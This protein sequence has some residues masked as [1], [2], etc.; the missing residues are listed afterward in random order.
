MKKLYFIGLCIIA[1]ASCSPTN[2]D[3]QNLGNLNQSAS[4]GFRGDDG[5][6]FGGGSKPFDEDDMPS[7]GI[8]VK[9]TEPPKPI[10]GFYSAALKRHAYNN[11]A[12]VDHVPQYLSGQHFYFYDR[13]LGSADGTGSIITAWINTDS[14]DMVLTTNPNEFNEGTGFWKK[15]RDFGNS[16]IGNE[17]GSFPIYR[18]F[19]SKYNSHFYTRDFNELGNGKN[20]FVYEGIAFYLKDSEPN[21][22]FRIHDG[23]FY[24]DN[25]TGAYYIVFESKLRLFENVETLTRLFDFRKESSGSRGWKNRYIGKVDIEKY[26]GPRGKN[27]NFNTR[28]VRDAPSGKTYLL[29]DGLLRYIPNSD[30]FNLYY[31][32]EDE[33]VTYANLTGFIG[34]EITKTY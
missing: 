9:N 26:M 13:F 7:N 33:V 6:N 22:S 29:D 15:H 1:L 30:I 18:Y 27:I 4:G 24:Q 25:K 2:D 32:K 17:P 10:Y 21:S 23:D 28:L 3:L 20:G 14:E 5:S 8:W 11:W 12:S 16:Y 19:I 31:F 34:K